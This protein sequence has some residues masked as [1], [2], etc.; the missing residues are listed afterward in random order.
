MRK[1]A[2]K[3]WRHHAS[4]YA[5]AHTAIVHAR[6]KPA[7][8]ARSTHKHT[9]RRSTNS[10]QHTKQSVSHAHT[11]T[12]T[13]THQTTSTLHTTH[14]AEHVSHPSPHT[15][16]RTPSTAHHTTHNIE[17]FSH[18]PNSAHH[19]PHITPATRHTARQTARHRTEN[20]PN[21]HRNT[22]YH[23]PH[24]TCAP[25]ATHHITPH[26]ARSAEHSAGLRP[27]LYHIPFQTKHLHHRNSGCWA[28]KLPLACATQLRTWMQGDEAFAKDWS[29]LEVS[30]FC[31][32]WLILFANHMPD[33]TGDEKRPADKQ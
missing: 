16:H 27:L 4:G 32:G 26:T 23:T 14:V 3:H 8:T 19:A 15:L 1:H 29:H 5:R 25:S 28:Q 11:H 12:H 20:A 31:L 10:A 2:G 21:T 22:T 18:T 17:H 30:M 24:A 9:K 13:R 33:C 6:S 7:F